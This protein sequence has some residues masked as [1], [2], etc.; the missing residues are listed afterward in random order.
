M[1]QVSQLLDRDSRFSEVRSHKQL[2]NSSKLIL[3]DTKMMDACL[4]YQLPRYR[5]ERVSGRRLPPKFFG[6]HT[7]Q[8]IKNV[9]EHL[10]AIVIIVCSSELTTNVCTISACEI[11]SSLLRLLLRVYRIERNRPAIL[12]IAKLWK[13][14]LLESGGCVGPGFSSLNSRGL[15]S[16][17]FVA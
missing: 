12:G 13:S 4:P 3:R 14:C 6:L 10:I 2:H 8:H 16:T 5:P 11:T 9:M 1:V 7:V 15:H 17:L